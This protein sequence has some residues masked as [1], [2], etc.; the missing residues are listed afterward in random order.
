MK[1]EFTLE[2]LKR[3]LTALHEKR[4]GDVIKLVDE[5]S[6]DESELVEFVQGTVEL[7]EFKLIDEFKA[8]NIAH[9]SSEDITPFEIVY[10]LD[11]DG[12][13]ELPLVMRLEVEFGGDG[14]NRTILDIEPN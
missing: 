2:L 8:E 3:I 4:F 1:K 10:Y 12:G 11:A 14:C 7:N 9:M 6:L 13:E 5:S